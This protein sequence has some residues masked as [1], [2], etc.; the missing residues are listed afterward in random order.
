M[1]LRSSS[2][3]APTVRI[4][5]TSCPDEFGL[6]RPLERRRLVQSPADVLNV[7]RKTCSQERRGNRPKAYLVAVAGATGVKLEQIMKANGGGWLEVRLL[8]VVIRF[9]T[10]KGKE[11]VA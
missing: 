10:D 4:S 8:V 6:C 3:W 9:P 1:E 7:I 11:R 5:S 2:G